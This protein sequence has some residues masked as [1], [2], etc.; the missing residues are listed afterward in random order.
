VP[1]DDAIAN[2]RVLDAARASLNKPVVLDPPA[3]HA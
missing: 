3:A 1:V 2:L